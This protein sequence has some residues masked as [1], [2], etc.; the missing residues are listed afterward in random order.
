MLSASLVAGSSHVRT[1]LKYLDMISSAGEKH[2]PQG[3][4]ESGA[5]RQLDPD[6]CMG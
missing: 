6:W 2:G 3:A 4:D 1:A 5:R